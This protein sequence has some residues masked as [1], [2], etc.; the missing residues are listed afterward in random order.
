MEELE[1]LY[2]SLWEQ[3]SRD[4]QPSFLPR[5]AVVSPDDNSLKSVFGRVAWA[6]ST[7]TVDSDIVVLSCRLVLHFCSRFTASKPVSE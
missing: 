5:H 1:T 3:R 4:E 2:R 6:L 7:T